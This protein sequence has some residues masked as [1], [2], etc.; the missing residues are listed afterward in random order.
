MC[1]RVMRVSVADCVAEKQAA[2]IQQLYVQYGQIVV[3]SRTC[4]PYSCSQ[5]VVQ[6]RGCGRGCDDGDSK[7]L[8]TSTKAL[9]AASPRK[10]GLQTAIHAPPLW[11]L[12][13]TSKWRVL[14]TQS[15]A[16]FGEVD[17][18]RRFE[19]LTRSRSRVGKEQHA[20]GLLKATTLA[21]TFRPLA[22]T[23]KSQTPAIQSL[24][25]LP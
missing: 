3:V 4:A 13:F 15:F 16:I 25:N 8:Q 9:T 17:I 7:T 12:D 14:A 19:W 21:S 18:Q 23:S 6:C 20:I 22:F 10:V 2:K 1:V 5:S 11:P 24:A